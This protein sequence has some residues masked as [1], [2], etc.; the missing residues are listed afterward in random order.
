MKIQLI[1][2]VILLLFIQC[3]KEKI[4]KHTEKKTEIISAI[5]NYDFGKILKFQFYSDSS[6][7]FT[8]IGENFNYEKVKKFTG[9]FYI[10]KDTIYISNLLNLNLIEA[11]KQ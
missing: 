11:A 4:E 3:K 5:N 6:Y 2:P 9:S 7:I 8:I 1:L 10:K